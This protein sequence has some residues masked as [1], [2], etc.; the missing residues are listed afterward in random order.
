MRN[1]TWDQ[2]TVLQT[3]DPADGDRYVPVLTM[4]GITLPIDSPERLTI[5]GDRWHVIRSSIAID[6]Q[7]RTVVTTVTVVKDS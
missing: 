4:E 2:R 7:T 3:H 6:T 1:A 5:H